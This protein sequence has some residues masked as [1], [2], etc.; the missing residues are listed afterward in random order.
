MKVPFLAAQRRPLDSR[1]A[2]HSSIKVTFDVYG[3]LFPHD[4]M[5]LD[6]LTAAARDL[7]G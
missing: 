5:N 1:R 2:G 4:S 3:D 7:L 6:A